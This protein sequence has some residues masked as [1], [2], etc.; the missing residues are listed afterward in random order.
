ME[1]SLLKMWVFHLHSKFRVRKITEKLWQASRKGVSAEWRERIMLWTC[2]HSPQCCS[3]YV[4]PGLPAGSGFPCNPP[5]PQPF[6]T[7]LLPSLLCCGGYPYLAA[8]HGALAAPFSSLHCLTIPSNLV[9]P[10][11]LPRGKPFHPSRPLIKILCKYWSQSCVYFWTTLSSFSFLLQS[12][13]HIY[14][15][16]PVPWLRIEIIFF[17]FSDSISY[18]SYKLSLSVKR[19]WEILSTSWL[20]LSVLLIRKDSIMVMVEN[21]PSLQEMYINS[22]RCGRK[23]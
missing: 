5:G 18:V 3:P 21:Q 13:S 20:F 12:S 1:K 14:S 6:P 7:E 10:T 15:L 2:W 11:N 22:I 19:D 9:L 4:L 17:V 16:F 23:H 8:G